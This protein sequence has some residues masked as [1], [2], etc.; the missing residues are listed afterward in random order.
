MTL[1]GRLRID[2]V[3]DFIC[4]C[5]DF[6]DFI[7]VSSVHMRFYMFVFVFDE[8]MVLVCLT[9]MSQVVFFRQ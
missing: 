7:C 5:M 6:Y 1:I 2:S 9:S 4:L 3:F 8:C